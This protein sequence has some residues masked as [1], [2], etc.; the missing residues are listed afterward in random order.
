MMKQNITGDKIRL[1]D[2]SKT[3]FLNAANR[4]SHS[5]EK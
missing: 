3:F 5:L 2:S 4:Y 1:F